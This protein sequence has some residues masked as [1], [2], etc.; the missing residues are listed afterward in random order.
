[1]R[2]AAL[3]GLFALLGRGL[4]ID[5]GQILEE[6]AD[7]VRGVGGE[8]GAAEGLGQHGRPFGGL[9][10]FGSFRC[11]RCSGYVARY[12][13]QDD[14]RDVRGELG[15]QAVGSVQLGRVGGGV[16]NSDDGV[17]TGAA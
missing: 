16:H 15:Q 13:G 6:P 14:V 2:T 3:Y 7:L 5:L 9:G 10:Y 8:G 11:F 17:E 12:D 1:M 4:E